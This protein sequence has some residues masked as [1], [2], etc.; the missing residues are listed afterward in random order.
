MSTA[1]R[2][3]QGVTWFP[4][5]LGARSAPTPALFK[6]ILES[7]SVYLEQVVT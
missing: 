5:L 7:V 2:T 6:Q 4:V 1:E 3:N